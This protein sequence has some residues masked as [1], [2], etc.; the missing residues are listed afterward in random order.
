V[1]KE[2]DWT[3]VALNKQSYCDLFVF[4]FD[5]IL[6]QLLLHALTSSIEVF[7]LA[8]EPALRGRVHGDETH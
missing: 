6:P 3:W 2:C 7:T 1:G 4:S 8:Q 5:V